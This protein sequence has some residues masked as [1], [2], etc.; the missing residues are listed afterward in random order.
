MKVIDSSGW[1]DFFTEGPLAKV[2][3][4][5]LENLSEIITPAIV[6]YEVYK[7]IK[8]ERGEEDALTAVMQMGKTHVIFIDD[9]LVLTAADLSLEHGLAM[10]D[11]IVYATALIHEAT[12]VTSDSDLSQL[13]HVTYLKKP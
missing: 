9:V 13:P 3:A 11:S 4:G 6:L 12:L 10:A 8:R 5:H 1:L 2:Y 7:I